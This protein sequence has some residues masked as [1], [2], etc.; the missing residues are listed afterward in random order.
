MPRIH[1]GAAVLDLVMV[2]HS[3]VVV[4]VVVVGRSDRSVVSA[5][6][7]CEDG[8]ADSP[9]SVADDAM[10][11]ANDDCQCIRHLDKHHLEDR[12]VLDAVHGD[13]VVERATEEVTPPLE[14]RR[15]NEILVEKG[16]HSPGFV[17]EPIDAPF[18][19]LN[20]TNE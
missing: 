17:P 14:Q 12:V 2:P 3:V 6:R 20:P 10:I 18:V 15:S 4:F 13:K 7:V 5:W 1:Q 9:S 16:H 11:D 8:I 19:S